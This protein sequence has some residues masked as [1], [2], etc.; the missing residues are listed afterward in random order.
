VLCLQVLERVREASSTRLGR[1]VSG[2]IQ[3]GTVRVW[4]CNADRRSCY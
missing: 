4:S 3:A 2:G 1:K